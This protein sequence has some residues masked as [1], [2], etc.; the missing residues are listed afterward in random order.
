[1]L[2]GDEAGLRGGVPMGEF[3]R[4]MRGRV[5]GGRGREGGMGWERAE[6]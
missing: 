4:G 3:G 6:S 2:G 1:M 5:R